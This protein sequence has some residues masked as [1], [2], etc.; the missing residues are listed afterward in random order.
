M[1]RLLNE[2]QAAEL[3]GIS[4]RHLHTLR[5][6]GEVPYIRLGGRVLYAPEALQR[7]IERRLQAA[8][9]APSESAAQ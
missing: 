8:E 9:A 2:R 6:R 3:L 4:A 7:W 1:E 5:K